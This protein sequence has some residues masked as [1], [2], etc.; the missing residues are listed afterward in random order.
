[1]SVG[2]ETK[3]THDHLL[4]R[5]ILPRIGLITEQFVGNY[6]GPFRNLPNTAT[7]GGLGLVCWVGKEPEGGRCMEVARR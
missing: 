3:T 4:Q 2:V 1:M 5:D 6:F 7:P